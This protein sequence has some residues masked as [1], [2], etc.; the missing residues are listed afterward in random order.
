ML[1]VMAD[2]NEL[3]GGLHTSEAKEAREE[4][5]LRTQHKNHPM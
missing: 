5:M 4:E 2:T 1:S 3:R